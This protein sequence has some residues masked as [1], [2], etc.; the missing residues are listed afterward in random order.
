[1]L[2]SCSCPCCADVAGK[3]G[4][5]DSF[6]LGI[7]TEREDLLPRV[8]TIDLGKPDEQSE[9]VEDSVMSSPRGGL[10]SSFASSSGID[11]SK[12]VSI[13]ALAVDVEAKEEGESSMSEG[14]MAVALA[15]V[16]IAGVLGEGGLDNL[17]ALTAGGKEHM[18]DPRL[19]NCYKLKHGCVPSSNLYSTATALAS[20]T[21]QLCESLRQ[22][23]LDRAVP[24]AVQAACETLGFRPLSFTPVAASSGRSASSR[25][26]GPTPSG[27]SPPPEG[28]CMCA[29]G[30]TM[31]FC[32]PSRS[33]CVAITVN[34][35]SAKRSAALT[36]AKLVSAE[37]GLG[38]PVDL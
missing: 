12:S 36:V 13:K 4:L 35:L 20:I 6:V 15:A 32:V 38:I 7:P 2:V 11:R 33:I 29:L 3:Y 19:I 34:Q 31:V 10:D 14:T 24:S 26:S 8:V 28:F 30:G 25:T 5:V 27:P 18:M 1:M 23:E 9:S 17:K 37:L 16:E 22:Q 21:G